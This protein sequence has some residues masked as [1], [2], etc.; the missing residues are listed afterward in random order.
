MNAEIS[1]DVQ[2]ALRKHVERAVRPVH[3]LEQRKL[4]MREE[5]LAHLAAI[6]VEEQSRLGDETAALA[7][8][9]ERFGD[10]A[11]LTAELNRSVGAGQRFA[12]TV[13]CW[14][15]RLDKF[16]GKQKNESLRRFAA[17]SLL[18]TTAYTIGVMV[19]V[20]GIVW[21]VGGRP[22]AGT[23]F[24]LPRLFPLMIVCTWTALIA[25]A[26]I[27]NST[28]TG[29]RRWALLLIQSGAWS[30]VLTA[31][32]AWFW[33][34]ISIRTF[35]LFEL[36]RLAAEIWAVVFGLFAVI[37]LVVDYCRPIRQRREAWTLLEID[38]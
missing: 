21:T 37:A 12:W 1:P 25:A 24:M 15:R 26:C 33:W 3:A 8:S 14:E 31:M 32:M 2:T 5:L 30:L 27:N 9:R 38:E 11:E 34:S 4:R 29:K 19:V 35:T 16:F 13:E 23:I 17:R 36:A 20:C 7:A 22:D 28:A 6:Y 18:T 10:P